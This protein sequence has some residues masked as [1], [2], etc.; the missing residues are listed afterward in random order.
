MKKLYTIRD[1]KAGYGVTQG[2]PAIIDLPNDQVAIRVLKGSVAKGQKPNALNIYP[3]DK[4]LWCV[5]EFDDLTGR[6]KPCLVGRSIDYLDSVEVET[7][8]SDQPSK[9]DKAD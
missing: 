7:D 1:V 2:V 3:E 5:G 8:E 9:T 4:E 6:I